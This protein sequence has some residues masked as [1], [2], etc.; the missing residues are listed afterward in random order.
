[1]NVGATGTPGMN[2]GELFNSGIDSVSKRGEQ[3]QAKMEAMMSKDGEIKTEDML[4][5]QFEMGQYNA[6]ME[7]LS[8]VT[9]SMTDLL[10]NL[11]QRAG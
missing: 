8:T 3:L 11:A 7:S 6:M 5:I 9:K 10:K 1:M 2:V 4:A